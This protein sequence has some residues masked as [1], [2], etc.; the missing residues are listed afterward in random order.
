MIEPDL[1]DLI[2]AEPERLLEDRDV[3]NALVAANERAMGSNIVD[4]R[5]IAM[6]RLETRLDRLEDTHRSVIAAAYENLAGTNQVHRAILQLLEPTSFEDFLKALATDVAQTLRVDMVRLVLETVQEDG[7]TD[8]TLRRLGDVLQVAPAGYG[9]HLPDQRPQRPRPP[10]RA[11]FH[12]RPGRQRST[13]RSAEDIRSE[14][15]DETRLRQGPSAGMLVFGIRRSRISSSP[16]TAPIFLPFSRGSSNALMRRW[17]ALSTPSLAP[18]SGRRCPSG[19]PNWPPLKGPPLTRSRPI[20]ATSPATSSS[21]PHHRGGAEGLASVATA[22][23]IRPPRLDGRGT[24][25][26]PLRPLAG[27][28][29]FRREGLHRLGCR[30]HR[31]GRHHRPLRPRTEVPPQAARAPSAKTV[32]AAMLTEIGDDARE[33]WIAARDTAIVTLLYGLGLRISEALSPDRGRPPAARDAAHHRQGRQDPPRPGHP[34]R[35]RGRRRLRPPLPAM[36]LRPNE[37]LFRGARGGPVNPRLIQGAMERARLRLGLPAT[38]TPHALRHSF[39]THLLSAGGD[40][41][42]IQEL[43][44]HASL[45]TTQGLHRRRRRAPDGSLRKSPP[46]RLT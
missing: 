32:R 35:R 1:R 17:L 31:R 40:L 18:P 39:A 6:Q 4:L 38:A 44:G 34:R 23:A 21:S 3:M 10:R 7:Q 19:L 41:R 26:R 43:L 16:R 11:A 5:G 45:S 27:P 9:Q 13:A 24:R 37:P 42:A 14:A 46:P 12:H 20:A 36:T 28:R 30:P 2:L 25:A 8:P 15:A 29:A 33:D 22:T